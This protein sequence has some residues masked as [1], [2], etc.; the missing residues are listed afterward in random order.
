MKNEQELQYLENAIAN[1]EKVSN[2]TKRGVKEIEINGQ[3]YEV[4]FNASLVI[5]MDEWVAKRYGKDV[6]I[7][8][9]MSGTF[10]EGSMPAK[11]IVGMLF[12]GLSHVQREL[13][14]TEQK[15]LEWID[16][17]DFDMEYISQCLFIAYMSG[18]P[19]GKKFLENVKA[20]HDSLVEE[21]HG[22][23]DKEKEDNVVD[24]AFVEESEE[25]KSSSKRKS[26]EISL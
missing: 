18:R 12:I 16:D 9:L 2:I 21:L 10:L 6:K 19:G 7:T 14:L 26:Q 4:R 8:D 1:I 15:I 23:K 13:R 25:K 22:K 3:T 11:L 17:D 5:A 24:A 20:M